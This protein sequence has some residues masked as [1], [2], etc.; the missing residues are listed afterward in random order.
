MIVFICLVIGPAERWLGQGRE[1]L[2]GPARCWSGLGAEAPVVF[3]FNS[4]A[5]DFFIE[6]RR[7]SV[8]QSG[9]RR[10]LTGD[11]Q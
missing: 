5:P 1:P 2:S 11:S 3:G 9:T 8:H 4:E 7:D 6:P 10:Y